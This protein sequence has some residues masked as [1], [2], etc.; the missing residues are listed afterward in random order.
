M[1]DFANSGY[2]TVVITAVYNAYFVAAI[3]GN[4]DWASLAWTLALAVSYAL[5]M[6]SAP[7]LGAW[8]DRNLAK[9]RL[10][11]ASV[12]GC[13][14]TTAALGLA[15]P[16]DLWLAATLVVASNFFFGTGENL[17]AAFLPELARGRGLGRLSGWGWGLGYLG[18]MLTLGLCLAYIGHAQGRGLGA[19]TFVPASLLITA[20]VF[21]LAS[22]PTFLFLRERGQVGNG[23]GTAGGPGVAGAYRQLWRSLGA[24][25]RFP[26]LARFL[27]CIVFY[28]AGVQAVIA[29]AAVYAQQ[30]M[31]FD[32]RETVVLILVVNVAAAFGALAF[33]HVQDRIGHRRAIA[34][35]LVGWLVTV[36]LAWLASDAPKFWLAANVAGLCLGASQSA[37]RALVG[38][39][40][41]PARR[42][43][44]FGLWGLAVKLSAILGPVT[45]G[46]AVWLSGGDHRLAMLSL[47]GYFLVGLAI[48]VF[49]D[50][51]RGRR[52]A[53]S[54]RPRRPARPVPT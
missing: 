54:D 49:V 2:T 22:L 20:G 50:P 4:A 15:G 27:V 3:A 1:F 28:Q 29:L 43:E 44:F 35:T 41:P 34:I 52:L 37:G 30:A 17:I 8:A 10:L 23:P 5:I 21:L 48:L 51:R 40:S 47:A 53:L 33:G 13:V 46:L 9:K 42:A 19:E 18:G 12:A 38:Y 14:L 39:L 26:D 36:V 31:H 32:T 7:G 11:A 25:R 16:G 45:Y 6:V 24:S